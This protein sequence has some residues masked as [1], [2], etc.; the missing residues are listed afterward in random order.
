MGDMKRPAALILCTGN[1][2]RRQMAEGFM[3]HYA[4]DRLNVFSAGTK[5][6]ADVHPLAVA[7]MAESGI[8]ISGHAKQV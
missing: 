7:V 1:S 6:A 3:R 2:C 8:D 5:L 4:G